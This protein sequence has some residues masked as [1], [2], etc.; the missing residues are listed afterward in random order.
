MLV[1]MALGEDP[2]TAYAAVGACL[3]NLGPGLGEAALNY[4]S[5]S[6]G[7]KYVSKLRDAAWASR[8]IY[9][10]GGVIAFILGTLTIT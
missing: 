9:L 3:N 6:D 1:C 4:A 8:I 7:T 10:V 2:I 5:L